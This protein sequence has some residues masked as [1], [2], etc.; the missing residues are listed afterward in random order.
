MSDSSEDGIDQPVRP[1]KRVKVIEEEEAGAATAFLQHR[2]VD[3][4]QLC[5]FRKRRGIEI[6]N[7]S[8]EGRVWID[9]LIQ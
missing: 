1:E 8:R 9:P 5:P 3:A 2:I 6:P 4:V 7:H